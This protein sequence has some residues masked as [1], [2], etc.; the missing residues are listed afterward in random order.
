MKQK[1][2]TCKNFGTVQPARMPGVRP[3]YRE[4]HKPKMIATSSKEWRS[5]TDWCQDWTD[6]TAAS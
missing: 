6:A 1:C 5:P 4:C 3:E 2:E